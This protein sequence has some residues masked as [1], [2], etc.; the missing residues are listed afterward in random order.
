MHPQTVTHHERL[1]ERHHLDEVL[2]EHPIHVPAALAG[3]PAVA[4]IRRLRLV[5]SI[6]HLVGIL[7]RI[8][9]KSEER[10]WK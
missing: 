5:G 1:D 4:G 10:R 6:V 2:E 8:E 7:F 9:R 3:R